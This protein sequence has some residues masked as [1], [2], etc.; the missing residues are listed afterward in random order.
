MVN[1]AIQQDRPDSM[2]TFSR[3]LIALR[4]QSE[5]L[6]KGRYRSLNAG[7][8]VLAF[9]READNERLVIV[10]NLGYKPRSWSLTADLTGEIVLSTR[11][12]GGAEIKDGQLYLRRH[13]GVI[14]Q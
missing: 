4:Q 7:E 5:A 12:D 10:L 6:L 14:L 9:V 13:E 3:R 2:L 11:L 8:D 1:V